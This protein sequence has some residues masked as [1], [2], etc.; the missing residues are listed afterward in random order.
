MSAFNTVIVPWTD[1]KSGAVKD[2]RVQFKYGDTWQHEYQ[3]GDKLFW[4]GNDIGVPNAT[5]VVVDAVVEGSPPEGVSEDFEIHIRNGIIEKAIPASG[6]YDL[7]LNEDGYI[8]LQ[9]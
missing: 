6:I 5:Y 2:L 3:I 7:A 8:V 9:E 4:G 1:P